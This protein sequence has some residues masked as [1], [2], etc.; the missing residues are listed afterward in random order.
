MLI[1]LRKKLRKKIADDKKSI[2]G[3]NANQTYTSI[4]LPSKDSQMFQKKMHIPF[5]QISLTKEIGCGS[6]GKVY[7]G[8]VSFFFKSY[9][10]LKTIANGKEILWLL[11]RITFLLT[12]P[13]SWQK[14]S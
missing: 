1:I 8:Y 11:K 2:Y 10:T 14:Q 9:L 7:L 12:R 6:F 3:D 4:I 13:T 5:K